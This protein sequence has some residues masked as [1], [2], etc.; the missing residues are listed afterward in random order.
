[1]LEISVARIS[2]L[3]YKLKDKLENNE[4]TLKT[5]AVWKIPRINENSTIGQ[6]I[7]YYRR[8]ANIKQTDL[9][10]KLGCDRGVLDRL[11]NRDL[12][13]VNINLIKDVIKELNI[14]DK[15]I[16]N[17]DYIAFLLD[18]PSKTIVDFRKKNSLKQVD[19]ARM[20]GKSVSVIKN[21]E[22]GKSQMTRASYDKLKKFFS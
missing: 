11:E 20:L 12:K 7:K 1:M 2:K 5:H 22:T 9:C 15:I 17:D 8:L 18:N 10:I 16:I 21:W 13:L 19:L 6:Q 14:E 3:F 4:I